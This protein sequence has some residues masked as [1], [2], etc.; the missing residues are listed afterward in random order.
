MTGTKKSP[1]SFYTHGG[2]LKYLSK[3]SMQKYHTVRWEY[4]A[5]MLLR[6]RTYFTYIENDEKCKLFYSFS[7]AEHIHRWVCLGKILTKVMVPVTDKWSSDIIHLLVLIVIHHTR[8]D[9]SSQITTSSFEWKY[10]ESIDTIQMETF[11][12]SLSRFLTLELIDISRDGMTSSGWW[13][14]EDRSFRGMTDT[15]EFGT[16]CLLEI[17]TFGHDDTS[18]PMIRYWHGYS[19]IDTLLYS[20]SELIY[21][22]L[23]I[24]REIVWNIWLD[25]ATCDEK[26]WCH[27]D[28]IINKPRYYRA[29][30]ASRIKMIK[31]CT[32]K[33]IKNKK[34]FTRTEKIIQ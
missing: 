10:R 12:S 6:E 16:S 8:C 15:S 25:V 20:L 2:F 32:I 11:P 9:M 21:T 27:R 29:E 4:D 34:I 1:K 19:S 13:D 33:F 18:N 31:I 30:Y 26:W 23:L 5:K 17:E 7:I 22:L 24:M 14:T 28:E 3:I